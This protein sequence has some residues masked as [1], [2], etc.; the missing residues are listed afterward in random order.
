MTDYLT[1]L[2]AMAWTAHGEKPPRPSFAPHAVRL[3]PRLPGRFETATTSQGVEP[4]PI[5]LEVADVADRHANA[6]VPPDTRPMPPQETR[7]LQSPPDV[8]RRSP[9][10]QRF[11]SP[12]RPVPE[13]PAPRPSPPQEPRQSPTSPPLF[14]PPPRRERSVPSAST[15]PN[16][17]P[18]KRPRR[19]QRPESAMPVSPQRLP[20]PPH[21]RTPP[22]EER[23]GT[24]EHPWPASNAKGEHPRPA[25][26]EKGE[27][28][29][30]ASNAK[31]ELTVRPAIRG[32]ASFAVPV[33]SPTRAERRAETLKPILLRSAAKESDAHGAE[34]P[35]VRIT[36]GR[37]E[38]HAPTQAPPTAP[39]SPVEAP[40]PAMSLEAYL[41]RRAQGEY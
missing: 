15:T 26:N 35:V 23:E 30:S 22:H 21:R 3:R 32:I 16:A 8:D 19:T 6:S 13:D 5:D 41:R 2:A 25:S 34:P 33:V 4:A 39:A 20:D 7:S 1:R 12:R 14:E 18:E 27:H 37:I 9:H 29:S 17:P 24:E 10:V 40:K 11:A 28:S 31:E 38:V 36:I